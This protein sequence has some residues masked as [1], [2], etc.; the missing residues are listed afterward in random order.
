MLLM[1]LYCNMYTARIWDFTIVFSAWLAG[2]NLVE[3]SLLRGPAINL[4]DKSVDSIVKH[5]AFTT[6]LVLALSFV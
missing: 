2:K 4:F 1:A 6:E 3:I 5:H